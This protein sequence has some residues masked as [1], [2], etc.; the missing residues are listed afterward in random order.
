MD[1]ISFEERKSHVLQIV[2]R[3]FPSIRQDNFQNLFKLSLLKV[4]CLTR[5]RSRPKKIRNFL[6]MLF[7]LKH[8]LP[9][10]A[11]CILFDIEKS[12]YDQI[13]NMEIKDFVETHA[14]NYFRI[15]T[16]EEQNN[17][18]EFPHTFM[19]VDS[20]EILIEAFHKQS[21]SGK[22]YNFTIKYQLLVGSLTGEIFHV[23]GPE[24]GSVHD[25][26]IWRN[27]G[28]SDFLRNENETVLGDKGYCGCSGVIHP[29]KKKTHPLTKS[30]IPF[31]QAEL[32]RNHNISKYR[33]LIE[34]VNSWIKDWSILSTIYRG[35]L[36]SHPQIFLTC[37]ILTTMT[38]E[39]FNF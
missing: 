25:A 16:R 3:Y 6:M 4:V 33:I 32:E 34:N 17:L 7:H 28:V 20:T 31:T 22:K 23:H 29:I 14:S 36:D 9:I 21:F 2:R 11:A 24:L 10:R 26:T 12:R 5:N 13:I 39:H 15:H 8:Y 1:N 30:K 38:S 35:E 18:P 19:I 27:S 37:C